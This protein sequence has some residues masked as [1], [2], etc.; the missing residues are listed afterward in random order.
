[1]G[2]GG[3]CI[4]RAKLKQY[5]YVLGQWSKQGDP[6]PTPLTTALYPRRFGFI[7]VQGRVAKRQ[8]GAIK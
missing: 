4:G 1:M 5:M 8:N 2:G 7:F 6:L 3:S